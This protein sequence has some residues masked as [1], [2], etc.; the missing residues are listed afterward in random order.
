MTKQHY[1]SFAAYVQ[2]DR[3]LTV[4]LYPEQAAAV[5]I[6]KLPGGKLY[7]YCNVHGLF[8]FKPEKKIKELQI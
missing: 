7:Y 4:K 6:L 1:I 8:V 3:V 5:R 2:F